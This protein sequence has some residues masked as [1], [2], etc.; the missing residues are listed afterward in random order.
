MTPMPR[1]ID[2]GLASCHVCG[3]LVRCGELHKVY[4]PRC[5]SALHLRKPNS[6][7]RT[8]SLLLTAMILY[9]PANVLPIM[10]TFRLGQEQADTI[11]S[12]VVYFVAH[13]D[14]PLALV[15][16]V[17]SIL[18]PLLKMMTLI[19]LLI[20]VQRCSDI[21]A[22]ER[23]AL[24]R[25]TELIGRWSM[26]DVFVVALL[27]ALVQMGNLASVLPGPGAGAFA[28]VVI[29]TMLAAQAFDPRLI[30]D[31]QEQRYPSHS[32]FRLQSTPPALQGGVA[33]APNR[34]DSPAAMD[35]DRTLNTEN[36][37][38]RGIHG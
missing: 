9:V 2:L 4:C 12:G 32:G 10:R 16:F 14:W 5:G 20:S 36:P 34:T 13:G 25:V 18:V 30:W 37:P 24:Y 3:L 7:A 23:T 22:R 38:A 29:L 19:Y 21:R 6:I 15:I 17:A 33:T 11:M 1:A 31:R 8:W 28:T 35:G 27:A 26:V